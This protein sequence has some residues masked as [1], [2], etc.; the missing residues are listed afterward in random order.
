V[1]ENTVV[2][3]RFECRLST[4]QG[5]MWTGRTITEVGDGDGTGLRTV[6]VGLGA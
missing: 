1:E 2:A 6:L 4:E 3:V 5:K